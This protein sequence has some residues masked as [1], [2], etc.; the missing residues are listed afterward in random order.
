VPRRPR[1]ELSLEALYQCAPEPV[2]GPR[3]ATTE[4]VAAGAT[5]CLQQSI[6]RQTSPTFLARTSAESERHATE[7][8]SLAIMPKSTYRWYLNYGNHRSYAH[9]RRP[10][11]PL[12][13]EFSGA[14]AAVRIAVG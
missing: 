4:Q 2:R 8:T 3:S 11:S 13:H 9:D 12:R 6:S 7:R 14:A 1:Y 10:R 5:K